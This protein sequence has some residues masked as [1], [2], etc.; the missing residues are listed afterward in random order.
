MQVAY[1]TKMFKSGNSMAVR[2]PKG[3]D[4]KNYSDIIIFQNH[5]EIIIKNKSTQSKYDLLFSKLKKIKSDDLQRQILP[6][7]ERDSYFD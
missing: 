5:D 6:N 4:L 1:D 3:I 7:Q 2:I